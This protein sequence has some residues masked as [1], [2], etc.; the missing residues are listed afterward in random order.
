MPSVMKVRSKKAAASAR[1]ASADRRDVGG[2]L[3]LLECP[4]RNVLMGDMSAPS[5]EQISLLRLLGRCGG[6]LDG[7]PV[8]SV[9]PNM[10]VPWLV[11]AFMLVVRPQKR[12]TR[13]S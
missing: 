4:F 9:D 10:G 7:A 11:N 12:C 13:P 1:L 3:G 5:A 2:Q 8:S 6:G